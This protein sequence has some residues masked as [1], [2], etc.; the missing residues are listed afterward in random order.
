MVLAERMIGL[1]EISVRMGLSI[2]MRAEDSCLSLTNPVDLEDPDI[3][4][5]I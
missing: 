5:L 1:R 2:P 3:I 4:T